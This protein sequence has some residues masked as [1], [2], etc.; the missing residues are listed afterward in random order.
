MIYCYARLR[1]LSLLTSAVATGLKR[2]F[3]VEYEKPLHV[4]SAT[5]HHISYSVWFLKHDVE[6]G[7][8]FLIYF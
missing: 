6:T 5:I 3:E 1:A 7:C 8:L 4:F 2:G